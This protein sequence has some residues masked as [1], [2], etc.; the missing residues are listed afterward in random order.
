M[1]AIVIFCFLDNTYQSAKWLSPQEKAL[2]KEDMA[3]SAPRQGAAGG[4]EWT[5]KSMLR[6]SAFTKC[7]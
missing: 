4:Q 2:I 7:G 1:I 3:Q 6:S 5:M